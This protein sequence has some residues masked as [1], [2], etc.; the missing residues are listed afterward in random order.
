MK[1]KMMWVP[2]AAL[3]LVAAACSSDPTESEEYQT[4]LTERGA[5]SEQLA[6]ATTDLEATTQ[7]LVDM[8]AALADSEAEAE[9][10]QVKL[11]D[12]EEE[13]ASLRNAGNDV[14]DLLVT[15]DAAMKAKAFFETWITTGFYDELAGLQVPM[16]L[17]DQVMIYLDNQWVTWRDLVETDALFDFRDIVREIGDD[18]LMDAWDR[19]LDTPVGSDEELAAAVELDLRLDLVIFEMINDALEVIGPELERT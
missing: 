1:L 16:E 4:L 9:T 18:E 10:L 11:T 3:L 7:E 8:T 5:L 19:W 12:R 2:M 6:D 13:V 15:A 17:G 14:R